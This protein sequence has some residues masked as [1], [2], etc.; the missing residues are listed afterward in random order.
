M[1]FKISLVILLLFQAI[2]HLIY[3]QENRLVGKIEGKIVDSET[4]TELIGANIL[5]V[6]STIGAATDL[7]GKYIIEN[8][9]IGNYSI[10]ISFLKF[11]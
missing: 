8:V 5:I 9:P 3:S 6:N 4:Q 1:N 7:D 11:S 10:K 2:F